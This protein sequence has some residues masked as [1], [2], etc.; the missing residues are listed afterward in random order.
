VTNLEDYDAQKGEKS[1]PGSFRAAVEAEGPRI[2][3]FR[4]GGTIALKNTLNISRPYLTIAG[5]TAPGGGICL[6]DEP[7]FIGGGKEMVLRYLRIRPGDT[8][9]GEI[10][11]FC[12][13]GGDNVMIDH[14]SVSWS[15]DECLSTLGAQNT[16]VQWTMIALP[17]NR[18][19]HKK[20]EHGLGSLIEGSVCTTFH[21]NLYAHCVTRAP[22]PADSIVLDFRNNVIYDWGSRAGY[23]AGDPVQMNYVGNYLKP[24]PETAPNSRKLA[25]HL[26]GLVK[27]YV[28]GNVMEGYPEA[29]ANNWLMMWHPGGLR[30]QKI[31]E[32]VGLDQPLAVLPVTTTSAE[33]AYRQVLEGCGATLPQRDR[34]DNLV[35]DQVEKG[36]GN[37]IDSQTDVGGWPDL[38]AGQAPADSDS[39]G[40]PDAW[41]KAHGL[42]PND[43]NDASLPSKD[44]SG[45][46]NIE[47]YINS[48]V[49]TPQGGWPKLPQVNVAEIISQARHTIAKSERTTEGRQ[50]TLVDR[51]VALAGLLKPT[52]QPVSQDK[53]AK[54]PKTQQIA[55]GD[56]VTMDLVLIH[57]GTFIMGSPPDELD[58]EDEEGPQYQ[59]TITRPFYLAVTETTD[60]QYAV[61]NNEKLRAGDNGMLPA[62]ANWVEA[63]DFCLKLSEKT[64]LRF[65]LPTEAQWEYACRAGTTTPFSTGETIS[66][67]QAAYD[68]KYVYGNGKPGKVFK[69]F[70]PVGSFPP[71]PWGLYDMHGNAWEWCYDKF[72]S[73][74]PHQA[75]TDP[76]G[77]PDEDPKVEPA[78]QAHMR[79]LR[80]GSWIARP[81]YLRSTCRYR[82]VPK[83]PFGFRVVME[84]E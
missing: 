72:T 32:K 7:V 35:I 46:T 30:D 27:A 45:Y 36:T 9:K 70:Q 5:Q 25:F 20:G 57:P 48:L 38:A 81:E 14:C 63:G 10:D 37:F 34:I 66:T 55:L 82:Y 79:V 53:A 40:M 76:I 43:P 2:V 84:V 64:G 49:P 80:G 73:K 3:V 42:N 4:V 62:Q 19:Y 67:D 50:E 65:R 16:T 52:T 12:I 58:R 83:N 47:V 6:K 74:Y 77:P 21:H 44:G 24:G 23:N 71:N 31:R 68:G 1:I 13:F 11:G 39:D 69:G 17:L 33:D 15:I 8:S 59:V 56:G 61:V 28:A 54:L 18:S 26:S 41:E 75:V 60:A 51:T 78:Y 22:R 29:K